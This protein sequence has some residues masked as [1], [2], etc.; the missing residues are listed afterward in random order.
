ML[1]WW[2]WQGGKCPVP[3]DDLVTVVQWNGY[4]QTRRASWFIWDCTDQTTRILRWLHGDLHGNIQPTYEPDA[5]GWIA[6]YGN[7]CPVD[8]DQSVQLRSRSGWF[9]QGPASFF[10]WAG[11][12][13]DYRLPDLSRNAFLPHCAPFRLSRDGS[14]AYFNERT[15]LHYRHPYKSQVFIF[16]E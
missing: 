5:D 12:Y 3:K 16:G 15:T 9:W 4:I 11:S 10:K 13:F 8:A 2:S 6:W 1:K 7:D 14:L